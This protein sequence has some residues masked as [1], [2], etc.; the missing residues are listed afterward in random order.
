M[1]SRRWFVW[2]GLCLVMPLVQADEPATEMIKI[3]PVQYEVPKNWKRQAPSNAM[4]VAQFGIPLAEGD[5]G[6]VEM[7]VFYF[8]P[9]QGGSVEDNIKRWLG[10]FKPLDGKEKIETLN[11]GELKVTLLDAKGT[12]DFKPFPAAPKGELMKDWRMLAS[13][14][15]TPND[16][17]YFFRMVGPAKTIGAQEEAFQ[18]MMKKSSTP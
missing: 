4:R 12:Y 9:D 17:P 15:E 7:T 13:V 2:A 11:V 16:G 8:G 1:T 5:S 14:V 6:K 3:G 10:Q 18:R